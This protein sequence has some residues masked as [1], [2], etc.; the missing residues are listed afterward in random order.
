MGDYQLRV[1][2]ADDVWHGLRQEVGWWGCLK[3][4][5]ELVRGI[6]ALLVVASLSCALFL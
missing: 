5:L 2:Q 4:S 3:I 1:D 6:G